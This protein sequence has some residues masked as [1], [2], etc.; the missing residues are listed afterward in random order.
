MPQV[1]KKVEV[2]FKLRDAI[3]A[4]DLDAAQ[5]ALNAGASAN[6]RLASGTTPL[7]LAALRGQGALISLLRKSG[8]RLDMVDEYGETALYYALAKGYKELGRAKAFETG[9]AL[10]LHGASPDVYSEMGDPLCNYLPARYTPMQVR[11]LVILGVPLKKTEFGP[12]KNLSGEDTFLHALS[13]FKNPE[14]KDVD[15]LVAAALAQGE[16]PFALNEK[17]VN[18]IQHAEQH[19]KF[20]VADSIL[21]HIAKQLEVGTQK[22]K[23]SPS[24]QSSA[25]L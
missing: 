25:R 14:R 10:I 7:M 3:N 6:G 9:K 16:D 13:Y 5:E 20:V 19:S 22:V 2:I 21:F 1:A 4:G 17:K 18:A 12:D 23:S 15:A 8:A 11:E 24:T